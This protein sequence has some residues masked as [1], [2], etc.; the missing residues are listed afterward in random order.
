MRVGRQCRKVDHTPGFVLH[1]GASLRRRAD[2]LGGALDRKKRE[3][4]PSALVWIPPDRRVRLGTFVA[5]ISPLL[6]IDIRQPA[7]ATNF[8]SSSGL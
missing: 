7:I 8:K 5:A 1:L 4:Y 2:T 6:A 3:D